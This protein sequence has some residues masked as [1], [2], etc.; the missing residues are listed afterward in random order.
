MDKEL[1]L[2]PTIDCFCIGSAAVTLIKQGQE[3]VLGHNG[4]SRAI[5]GT[6]DDDNC[7][8]AHQL[9]I[10]LKPNL[11]KEAARIHQCK[12]RVFALQD[13]L[14]VHGCG[15][16]IVILLGWQWLEPLETSV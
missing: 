13:E 4:D 12:G 2:H 3:L 9:T 7:L 16:P 6:R 10:D 14:E 15:C 1:K 5:M 11:P 8:V